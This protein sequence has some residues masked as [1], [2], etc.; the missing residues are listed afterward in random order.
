MDTY[1]HTFFEM[2]G[3]WSFGDYFK[4][5]AIAWAW[6]L[7]TEV[8]GLPQDR[9]YATYFEGDEKLGLAPDE[10]A[11]QL[12]LKYLPEERVLPGN[13]KDNFWEM[14]DT[15]PCGPC[16]EIHFDR[17]G[18]RDAAALVNQDDP[19]V[20]EV[21]NLVFMQFNRETG[22]ELRPLPAKSVDTGMGFERLVSVLQDKRSNYD[23][24][25]F[26]PI[27]AEIS[28]ITGA[29]PYGGALG[30][31]SEV[32]PDTAI[33]RDTAYRV[34]ADHIRTLSTAIADGAVPSNEGR[35]YVLRRILRRAVRYGRQI[36]G[37]EE[38]FFAA[39]VPGAVDSLREA[40]PELAEKQALVQEVIA[41]EEK[42]FSSMLSRG[43]KEFNARARTI[44]ERGEAGFDGESAFFL[45]DSMGFPLDLTELMA[46]EVGL[47]VDTA[48]FQ[49]AMDEQKA[50][51]AAAA[52]ASKGDG[53]LLALGAE[54]TA[55]LADGGVAFTDDQYK[56][57]RDGAQTATLRAI[58]TSDGFADSA[59]ADPEATVG[60]VLDRTPFFSQAGGQVSDV[61]KLVTADGATFRVTSVQSFGGYVLH[62]GALEQGS[63]ATG[64]AVECNVDW[65]RRQ[66]VSRSHSLTHVINLALHQVLG[67]GVNQKGSL[68]D[69]SKARF[70]FSHGKAMSAKECEQV[71]A[72][73]RES[74][75]SELPVH[76]QTVPLDKALDK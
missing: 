56:F 48:G 69:E 59:E 26:A 71:E 27:F 37:A 24:D 36:L 15:G 16:S 51:S 6:E 12:W 3:S 45:Y 66:L 1:H 31:A 75:K 23:T 67:D 73:V 62:L 65:E 20:L 49:A 21:W 17:I 63:L 4:E 33:G 30:D 34:I 19:D 60:L 76:I 74:V 52:A 29:A 72:L 53:A 40:F 5:E 7:F 8:Y 55:W 47:S 10:E 2:L 9:F 61:G 14:G 54:Q 57:D 50:R 44:K 68:V 25:V 22:G 35:G 11:R 43:I 64:A 41:D 13:A 18:G 46:R 39:L 28:R 70:D 38:G 58:Y 42:A 32:L